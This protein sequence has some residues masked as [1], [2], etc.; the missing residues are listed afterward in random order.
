[1]HRTKRWNGAAERGHVLKVRRRVS[2][3]PVGD[4]AGREHFELLYRAHVRSLL[5]YALRRVDQPEDAADVVAEAMLVAWRRQADVPTGDGARLW[6]F[7]VARRV[8]ANH[9][10]G[11]IRRNQLGDRLRKELRRL[12]VP[13][14]AAAVEASLVVRAALDEM[15]Q[16]DREVLE[17]TAWEGLEPH[18]VAVVLSI[19]PGTVRSRIHRARRRLGHKLEI[20]G[21]ETDERSATSGHVGHDE[22]PLVRNPEE[23]AR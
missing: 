9:R 18:E 3:H 22:P 2:V 15:S 8:L 11:V 4:A 1:V 20:A 13:D 19:S 10:R 23:D 12:I 5:A 7:G 21:T 6:L 16:F 14:H 17:L